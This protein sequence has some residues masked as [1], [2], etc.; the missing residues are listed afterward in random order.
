MGV[1]VL[2]ILLC[3]VINYTIK[4][5]SKV[6]QYD[7]VLVIKSNLRNSLHLFEVSSI[8]MLNI[9]G[10]V[11]IAAWAL[12]MVECLHNGTEYRIY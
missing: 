5:S 8:C 2:H 10:W 4:M 9:A 3:K 12:S 6:D 11:F 1:I 7:S